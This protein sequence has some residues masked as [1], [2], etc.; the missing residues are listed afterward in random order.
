MTDANL[1]TRTQCDVIMSPLAAD[2]VF[3]QNVPVVMRDSAII[4]ANVFRPE[5]PGNYPVI[6]ATS[7][8]GKDGFDAIDPFRTV[9]GTF[10]PAIC[11]AATLIFWLNQSMS[12][13]PSA[14]VS[15]Q[16]YFIQTTQRHD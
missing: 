15:L 1:R 13:E 8:Y 9:P 7:P 14:R 3:E 10:M 5:A 11:I 12:P 6:M 4:R 16:H 2:I